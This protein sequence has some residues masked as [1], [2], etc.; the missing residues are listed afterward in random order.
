MVKQIRNLSLFILILAIM[1]LNQPILA[2]CDNGMTL[3]CKSALLIEASTGTV[4]YEKNPHEKLEPASVTKIMTML[5]VMEA[6]DSGKITLEDKVIISRNASKMKGTC[7]ILEEGEV[8]TV[9][10]LITGIAVESANDGSV[11]IAEYISGDEE[12]F[13][14]LM[15]KRA[16]ELGMMD[17]HFKNSHG[18]HE[19]GHVTSA[20]DIGIMSRELLQHE[21]IF[22][23]ISIYMVK[24]TVGKKND[25]IRELANKNKMIRFYND[26]DGIKTGYTDNAM[27]CIS[28]TAKRNN[29]RFISVIMGAPSTGIRNTDARKLLDYGFANYSTY[30]VG[31]KGETIKTV[32]IAK[33]SKINANAVLEKDA[34]VLIKKGEEKQIEKKI[35]IPD[36][37][38]APLKKGDKLGEIILL[39][40]GEALESVPVVIDEDITRA[41]FFNN[42]NKA[43]RYWLGD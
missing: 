2:N 5:L 38:S 41:G 37:V 34:G 27:Y 31:K 4:I 12:E 17:T 14:M 36:R 22:D 42:I 21:K 26:V 40:N 8:R 28:A 13:A 1:V 23:F 43:I 15:N 39:K 25:V 24:V 6:L 19:E 11:A 10:D 18:L 7:L 32:D 20:Y 9:K 33:G 3:N 16:A 29:L 30:V 35:N